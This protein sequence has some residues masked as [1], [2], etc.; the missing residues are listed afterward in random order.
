MVDT[1]QKQEALQAVRLLFA[2]ACGGGSSDHKNPETLYR[3]RQ[4]LEAF[5]TGKPSDEPLLLETWYKGAA[6]RVCEYVKMPL[7]G[8]LAKC[9]IIAILQ[10]GDV[11][12]VL[13][14]T[15]E[16]VNIKTITLRDSTGNGMG[17]KL[18]QE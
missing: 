12:S 7:N 18:C 4:M 15:G 16:V 17:S 11:V 5:I 1:T 3:A 13:M 14:P 10:N 8:A 2:G 6:F 9:P